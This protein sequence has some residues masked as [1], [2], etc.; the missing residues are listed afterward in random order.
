MIESKDTQ[1]RPTATIKSIVK[2]AVIEQ[3]EKA[4]ALAKEEK[5]KQD[6]LQKKGTAE[7]KPYT[8][9]PFDQVVETTKE[10]LENASEDDPLEM[11]LW[12]EFFYLDDCI[13]L[14]KALEHLGDV[15]SSLFKY[16]E[17]YF[18]SL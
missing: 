11:T 14:A 13:R 8:P 4:A 5:A 2:A 9:T 18:L 12:A 15:K 3:S 10:V 1:V 16:E 17:H 6:G 7:V